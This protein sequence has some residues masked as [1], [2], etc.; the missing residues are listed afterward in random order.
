MTFNG[1]MKRLVDLFISGIFIVILSPL[2]LII[3]ALIKIDS[4]GTILFSQERIG[5]DGNYFFMRKF[6]TMIPDAEEAGTG[7]FSYED[8]PRIT[9]VGRI[10][11]LTS[12]DE[13][14][15]LWNVFGGSMSLVGPRPPVTYELGN[16]NEFSSKLKSR[17][18][19]KP[20]V[21]GLAQISGRNDLSWPEKIEYD[22]E[23]IDLLDKYGFLFDLLIIIKTIR[24]VFAMKDTVEKDSKE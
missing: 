24:V 17:F 7:L 18:R 4:K 13:L 14:P 23:Y 22:L 5:K 9:R 15:Q 6:S 3:S 10:L 8:D 19:V 2:L 21:T 11:R 20:G 12:L 16:Y 1:V